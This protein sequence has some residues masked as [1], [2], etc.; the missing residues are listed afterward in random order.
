M[1]KCICGGKGWVERSYRI[2]QHERASTNDYIHVKVHCEVCGAAKDAVVEAAAECAHTMDALMDSMH[3]S[4]PK[5]LNALLQAL[6]NLEA[7]Q[8]EHTS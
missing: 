1:S 3:H 8:N 5:A 6:A 4:N 2:C 7:V